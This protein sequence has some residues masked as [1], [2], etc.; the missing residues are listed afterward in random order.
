MYSIIRKF[1][2]V[3][4][5]GAA[6]LLLT[7]AGVLLG[8]AASFVLFVSLNMPENK[9]RLSAVSLDETSGVSFPK[10]SPIQGVWGRLQAMNIVPVQDGGLALQWHLLAWPNP[11]FERF[12]LTLDQNLDSARG[13]QTEEHAYWVAAD[14]TAQRLSPDSESCPQVNPLTPSSARIWDSTMTNPG[15]HLGEVW[16]ND[17]MPDVE[18]PDLRGTISVAA[19]SSQGSHRPDAHGTHVA[20]LMSALRNGEGTVGVVPGLQV[21]VYPL[22]V[23]ATRAGPR[24]SGQEV[25]AS[26]DSIILSLVARKDK[27][28]SRSRVILLSWAFYE[29]D[30]LTTDFLD[31]LESKIEKILDFDVALVV[32]AGNFETG[33]RSAGQRIFPAAW[34]G[35]FHESEGALLPVSASDV[36]SRPAWFSQLAANELGFTLLAPGER[37]YSTLI[38]RDFG[39]MSGTSASAAQVAAVL[40]MTSHQY[41]DVDMKTQVHTLLRTAMPVPH[42]T[43]RLVSFDA[44]SLIQGLMAEYGWIAR[45]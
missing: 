12:P 35:R 40:G 29:S 4:P 1:F 15:Q 26:L 19:S 45:H 18:H 10:H 31:Q 30:G 22:S 33:R 3:K 2:P 20:G 32:P 9:F 41:P 6:K 11:W 13:V 44:P 27:N 5:A 28:D 21:K 16:L 37:I 36:C 8:L 42:S 39:F 25:L 43:E 14:R 23:T 38:N 17:S 24:V 34:A 7:A